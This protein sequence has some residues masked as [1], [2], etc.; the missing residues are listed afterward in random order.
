M[1]QLLQWC[2]GHPAKVVSHTVLQKSSLLIC[3]LIRPNRSRRFWF[4][5]VGARTKF[6]LQRTNLKLNPVF[7]SAYRRKKCPAREVECGSSKEK[8]HFAKLCN[9]TKSRVNLLEEED[10][11]A[12]L[13]QV[14][15]IVIDQDLDSD[16]EYVVLSMEQHK[17]RS[18]VQK[19]SLE[20]LKS[21]RGTPRSLSVMLRSEAKSFYATVDTGSLVS[22]L[23]KRTSLILLRQNPK[24][25][26]TSVQDLPDDVT[27]MD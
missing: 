8:G 12:R 18:A 6:L 2:Q 20:L 25:R 19:R 16:P 22:L 24:A 5:I 11:Q 13:K 26:F 10:Y 9:S 15:G 14:D 21:S 3:L 7:F 1:L 4:N 23:N 27:Y 17:K